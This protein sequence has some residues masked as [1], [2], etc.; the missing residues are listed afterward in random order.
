MVQRKTLTNMEIY[1]IATL[2]LENFKD[3]ELNLPVKVNFYFQK[4][5]NAIV[6]MAQDIDKTRMAIFEKYGT[7]SEDGDQYTFPSDVT[8]TVNN[9]LADLFALEQEV[10]VNML[11]LDWFDGIN[12]TA[13]QVAAIEYM[14]E[15]ED[16]GKEDN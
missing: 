9:E 11:K 13:R 6:T 5:M 3:E 15:D 14:I 12:L 8:D 4:N 1:N 7:K 2:L 10:K 16:E